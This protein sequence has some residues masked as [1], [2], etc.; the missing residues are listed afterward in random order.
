MCIRD[1]GTLVREA[2]TWKIAQYVLS[3][4]IPNAIAGDVVAQ[5]QSL[6]AE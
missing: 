2:G 5:I 6:D 3:F 1:S 4:P